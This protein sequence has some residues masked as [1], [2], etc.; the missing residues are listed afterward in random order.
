MP[1][2][3][4]PAPPPFLP[5]PGDPAVPWQQWKRV[6]LNFL[7]AIGG[8]ELKPKRCK[9][10]LLNSLGVEGQRIFYSILA[11]EADVTADAKDGD[12]ADQFKDALAAL[13]THFASATND[14]V[15][16]RRLRQRQLP[17]ETFQA[18]TNSLR[19]LACTSNFGSATDSMIRGQLLEGT[20]SRTTR[21]RML[22]EGSSL[23]L[24]RAVDIGKQIEQTQQELGEFAHSTVNKIQDVRKRSDSEQ[25][26]C[27]RCGSSSHMA[28]SAAC[29]ATNKRC[30][31]CGKIGH[32]SSMCK[33][34][35]KK[36][37]VRKPEKANAVTVL[38]IGDR[39]ASAKD[40]RANI[41]IGKI[42]L[43]LIVDTSATVSL[44]S[45]EHYHKYLANTYSLRP[46]TA[47]LCNYSG[48]QIKLSG[49]NDRK[50][51]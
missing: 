33:S 18:F 21:E 43:S 38:Q 20:S 7:E 23:T 27:Y 45:E 48:E 26:S 44:L 17:G 16:R 5:A 6:F 22:Y 25:R 24:Q 47:N 29:P 42:R 14:L 37:A 15:E 35:K 9:A 1:L 11:Q 36:Y 46:P 32:F 13:D 39:N 12:K 2:G 40:V 41:S 31:S 34:K 49:W 4:F 28:N 30:H 8:D 19:D 3:C 51:S 50:L 10:N